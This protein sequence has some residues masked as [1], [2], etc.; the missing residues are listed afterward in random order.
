MVH[1]S[2]AN[3]STCHCGR[4]GGQATRSD[5]PASTR[6]VPVQGVHRL[7]VGIAEMIISPYLGVVTV[8]DIGYPLQRTVV[9]SF[10]PTSVACV[11][12]V[13]LSCPARACGGRDS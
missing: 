12:R 5:F 2:L 7:G 11:R 1:T 3:N 8:R 4:G 9:S 6:L 10:P 13:R